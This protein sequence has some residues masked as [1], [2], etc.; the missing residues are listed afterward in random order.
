MRLILN[1]SNKLEIN[2]VLENDI[3]ISSVHLESIKYLS[4]FDFPFNHNLASKQFEEILFNCRYKSDFFRDLFISNAPDIYN[5][6]LKVVFLWLE[7]LKHCLKYYKIEEI[8]FTDYVDSGS[9]MPFYEAE[10]EVNSKLFYRQFDFI[11]KV[12]KS[13]LISNHKN[14][15]LSILNNHLRLFLIARVFFRRYCI[16]F[17]K[18]L[19]Y[20]FYSIFTKSTV[21]KN[22]NIEHVFVSRSI[23]HT[24]Y[25]KSIIEKSDDIA[26]FLCE[27]FKYKSENTK[28][29]K[30]HFPRQIY[31]M[32]SYLSFIDVLSIV[33]KCSINIFKKP[34]ISNHIIKI[35]DVPISL[36]NVYIEILISH[37]DV[38]ILIRSILNF[39]KQLNNIKSIISCEMVTQYSFFINNEFNKKNIKTVQLQ[40]CELDY[41]RIPNFFFCN[42]F[43]FNSIS[44]MLLFKKMYPSYADKM[45][46]KGIPICISPIITRK[47]QQIKKVLFFSQNHEIDY[48]LEIIKQISKIAKKNIKFYIKPHPRENF[49]QNIYK[50]RIYFPDLFIFNEYNGDEFV[51]FDIAIT[52]ISSITTELILLGIPVINY[53]ISKFDLSSNMKFLDSSFPTNVFN[54]EK[55]ESIFLNFDNFIKDYEIF[56][57][58]FIEINRMDLGIESLTKSLLR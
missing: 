29:S 31:S 21:T 12:L 32:Y 44:D 49:K 53:P 45:I 37:V 39:T 25:I 38:S 2:D 3:V 30:F 8:V 43:Y 35:N 17:F 57:K 20:I 22:R 10:G 24:K 41:Y 15:Q 26:L 47:S 1:F 36:S 48:Q 46:F 28:F 34:V 50:Y 4:I 9:Y 42:E 19:Y 55:L 56:R 33:F 58:K 7:A 52:R 5:K 18:F 23:V 27:A 51:D 11:P 40:T 54:F 13:Y 6:N 16:L 14:I